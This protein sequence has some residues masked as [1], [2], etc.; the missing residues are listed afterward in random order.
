LTDALCGKVSMHVCFQVLLL[1][2]PV[3]L[4]RDILILNVSNV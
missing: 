4:S 1:W 2:L 3:T